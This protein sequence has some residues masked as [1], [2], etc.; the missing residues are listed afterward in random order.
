M[1]LELS[2]SNRVQVHTSI[3]KEKWA[4]IG[5]LAT[6]HGVSKFEIIN[7]LLTRAMKGVNMK[8]YPKKATKAGTK[9]PKPK[10]K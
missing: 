10:K 8:A 3:T 4:A 6:T 2:K 5:R 7:G 9:K 1:T